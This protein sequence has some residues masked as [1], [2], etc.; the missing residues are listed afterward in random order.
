[1][2]KSVCPAFIYI[3]LSIW[4]H[5]H[6]CHHW[7]Y[8]RFHQVCF[9]VVQSSEQGSST[10]VSSLI[11]IKTLRCY[12]T[13]AGTNADFFVQTSLAPNCRFVFKSIYTISICIP[14]PSFFYAVDVKSV[15]LTK[16]TSRCLVA[17]FTR[18]SATS[19][20]T[21]CRKSNISRGGGKRNHWP[22]LGSDSQPADLSTAHQCWY[23]R[24]FHLLSARLPLPPTS[25]SLS[26]YRP[27]RSKSG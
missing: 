25:L 22:R 3:S 23:M 6:R 11:Q 10:R 18:A 13:T 1:M 5:S 2:S 7:V 21:S 16:C 27:A 9:F 19:D 26:Q 17:R 8:S 14:T 4:R 20:V 24:F 12:C 15:C